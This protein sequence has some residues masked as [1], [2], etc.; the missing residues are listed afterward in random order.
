MVRHVVE[1][2]L[3][4][5]DHMS[6][7]DDAKERNH[8]GNLGTNVDFMNLKDENELGPQNI[9]ENVLKKTRKLFTEK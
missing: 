7:Q 9:E 8:V 6:G 1:A 2:L 4:P 3:S 5:D